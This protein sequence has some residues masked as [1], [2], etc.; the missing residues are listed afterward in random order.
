MDE[1]LALTW[2]ASLHAY[3]GGGDLV[4]TLR[5]ARFK[6]DIYLFQAELDSGDEGYTLVLARVSKEG[7]ATPLA[8]EIPR[9]SDAGFG[10][11][12]SAT[13]AF[14]LELHGDRAGILGLLGSVLPS[15]KPLMRF[16]RW[17]PAT[18]ELAA[19]G[20]QAGAGGTP[21]CFE[22]PAG[23]CVQGTVIDQSGAVVPGAVVRVEARA[24]SG[25][26]RTATADDQRGEFLVTGLAAGSYVATIQLAGFMTVVTP[27]FTVA[28][29]VT[30]LF[31]SPFELRVA[32]LEESVTVAQQPIAC[33]KGRPPAKRR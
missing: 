24:G 5:V 14:G 7:D 33:R 9:S 4:K 18:S 15:C 6:G 20:A 19:A 25:S 22:C 16:A 10:V 21:G 31:E 32:A 11:R 12:T 2:D 27:A 29:S 3:K 23:A 26:T 17:T 30:Y 8:C 1:T 28:P 13:N